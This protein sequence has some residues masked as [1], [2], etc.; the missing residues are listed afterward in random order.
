MKIQCPQ[1]GETLDEGVYNK[2]VERNRIYNPKKFEPVR[3]QW[4][5]EITIVSITLAIYLGFLLN[6]LMELL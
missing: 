2:R 3:R 4:V 1:C 5:I 6:G